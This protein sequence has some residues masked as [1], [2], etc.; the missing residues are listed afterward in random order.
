ML[1]HAVGFR[2]LE[3]RWVSIEEA[4]DAAFTEC[5]VGGR[6][7]AITSA[8]QSESGLGGGKKEVVD[9][10]VKQD[11]DVDEEEEMESKCAV[12]DA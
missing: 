7:T 8:A 1:E 12:S 9:V 5:D 11:A 2:D 3:G 6:A 4:L 10:N